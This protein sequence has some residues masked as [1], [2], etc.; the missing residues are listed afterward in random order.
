MANILRIKR[1]TG[2][3][4]GLVP[5]E[6]AYSESENLLYIGHPSNGAATQISTNQIVFAS[7]TD[8]DKIIL[9]EPTNVKLVLPTVAIL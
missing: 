8:N 1:G 5:G 2:T 4:S 9:A 7:S 3:P 6:L